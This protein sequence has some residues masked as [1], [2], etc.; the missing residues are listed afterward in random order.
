M[1]WIIARQNADALETLLTYGAMIFAIRLLVPANS[2]YRWILYGGGLS[3]VWWYVAGSYDA[4]R[5]LVLSL[6]AFALCYSGSV[7]AAR[8]AWRIP[9]V[10]AAM[11]LFSAV[12]VCC[13]IGDALPAELAFPTFQTLFASGTSNS[14]NRFETV[15]SAYPGKHVGLALSGGG[16]RAA[17]VEAGAIAALESLQLPITHISAVS[18]GSILGAYYALGG[19]PYRMANF[20]SF[21]QFNARRDLLDIQNVSRLLLSA[22]IPGLQVRLLPDYKFTR[23]QVQANALDRALLHGSRFSDIAT[24][25]PRLMLGMTDLVSGSAVGI[26]SSWTM[27]RFLLAPP[28]QEV[29]GAREGAQQSATSRPSSFEPFRAEASKLSLLVAASGAVPLAFEP[30][31]WQTRGDWFL[32][33]DGG[34]SDTSGMTLLLEADRRAGLKPDANGMPQGD[35][36]W[37]LDLAIAVDGGAMFRRDEFLSSD[38]SV[39]DA[40]RRAIDIVQ[41]RLGATKP[42]ESRG[43]DAAPAP[44]A[45]WL[46]PS[47]Y[48][49]NSSR[50]DYGRTHHP[51]FP[52]TETDE[53]FFADDLLMMSAFSAEEQQLFNRVAAQVVS[54]DFA[55]LKVFLGNL[56]GV[57]HGYYARPLSQLQNNWISDRELQMLE[58]HARG[59]HVDARVIRGINDKRR[60]RMEALKLIA[61]RAAQDLEV[62]LAVFVQTPT[63]DDDIDVGRAT[64]LFRLGQYLA[65]LRASDL[66]TALGGTLT[67]RSRYVT[68]AEQTSVRC[69]IDVLTKQAPSRDYA[70]NDDQNRRRDRERRL[71]Q[72]NAAFHGCL[73]R[74][75]ADAL[76]QSDLSDA[77]LH[78]LRTS[79][80][81]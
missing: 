27:T 31:Q 64:D 26:T 24:G 33:S 22:V 62:A 36:N 79:G 37:A 15:R 43:E 12:W 78:V 65:F 20:V 74:A 80:H 5:D 23:T 10:A 39:V 45:K 25:A 34:G 21:R 48:M 4:E 56:V 69:T 71:P 51:E 11:I 47:L 61:F 53:S 63:L 75:S 30:V 52:E 44:V 46:S 42:A 13:S 70:V 29:F 32:L 58:M 49:D 9:Q 81:Y 7:L 55:S 8:R 60:R 41:S 73:E 57:V 19:D 1:G 76:L 17:V 28:G 66:R 68:S 6:V 2:R 67:D 50:Y 35:P 16:Y 40:G 3:L 54:L 18:G 59:E 72:A 77:S 38:L 14:H